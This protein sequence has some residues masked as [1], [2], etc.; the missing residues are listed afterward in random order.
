MSIINKGCRM[1]GTVEDCEG[2]VALA[3]E[4]KELREDTMLTW[5]LVRELFDYKDGQLIWVND[6]KANKVSGQVAGTVSKD[7]YVQIKINNRLYK[8]HRLIFLWHKGYLP[9][10]IDHI[11]RDPLN[12][13]IDNLRECT[14]SENTCNSKRYSTNTSGFKGVSWNTQMNKWKA[15]VTV[16]GVR[17][18]GGYYDTPEEANEVTTELRERLHGDFCQHDSEVVA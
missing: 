10:V 13:K 5:D 7:R 3:V 18:F 12:N 9:A 4:N 8:A 14:V 2:Y 16:N 15:E 11:D 6:R 1:I 17:H